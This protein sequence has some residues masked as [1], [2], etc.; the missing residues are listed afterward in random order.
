[1][2]DIPLV[3]LSFRLENLKSHVGSQQANIN[4]KDDKIENLQKRYIEWKPYF[5]A[6]ACVHL[7]KFIT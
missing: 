2:Y 7:S 4:A 3:T 5:V 6:K 1:M